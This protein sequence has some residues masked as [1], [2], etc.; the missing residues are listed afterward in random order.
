[1][2]ETGSD[3]Q[4]TKITST[5][6]S[7]YIV[8][9]SKIIHFLQIISFFMNLHHFFRV[10]MPDAPCM[11]VFVTSRYFLSIDMTLSILVVCYYSINNSISLRSIR[12]IVI[13]TMEFIIIKFH[14]VFDLASVW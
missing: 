13:I 2:I 6:L 9:F 3:K 1:M 7:Y 12:C 5:E 8:R 4:M 10:W 11:I 14:Y